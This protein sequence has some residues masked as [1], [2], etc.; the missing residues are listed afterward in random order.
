[1]P[2]VEA[3]I[4]SLSSLQHGDAIVGQL[5]AAGDVAIEPLRK[6]LIEGRPASIFEPRRWAVEALGG[7][8]ATEILLEY[9]HGDPLIS[10]PVI[11]MGEDAVRDAAIRELA[12]LTGEALY[13]ELFELASRRLTP[14]LVEVLGGFARLEAVP[15][16]D[17]ALED[18]VCRPAAE[19]ALRR[20]GAPAAQALA[21]SA[22][23]P[24]PGP[25]AESQSS[26]RRRR[27]A[28][29]L[30]A[31]VGAGRE[32]WDVVEPL[33]DDADAEIAV[34]AAQIGLRIGPRTFRRRIGLRVLEALPELQWDLRDV[35]AACLGAVLSEID[36]DVE[37]VIAQRRR[38]PP[39]RQ[40]VDA[41][42]ITLLRLRGRPQL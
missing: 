8:R 31:E 10:D 19:E 16:L 9:L 38:L 24:L 1:M 35:A 27:S 28:L 13:P 33:L 3:L 18:D 30:L 12:S 7:L 37:A 25:F 26:I 11:R 41:T 14:G 4:Q 20:M 6:F 2:D 34:L 15:I 5:I 17:R 42:L 40:A 22:A 23:T 39:A 21:L 29:R 36:R 32:L